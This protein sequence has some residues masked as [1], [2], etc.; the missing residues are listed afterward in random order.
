MLIV[1]VPGGIRSGRSRQLSSNGYELAGAEQ[2]PAAGVPPVAGDG[3]QAGDGPHRHAAA[4]VALQAVVQAD[5][6]RAAEQRREPGVLAGELLDVVDRQP[7]DVRHLRRRVLLQHALAE[8]LRAE[9]VA[10]AG[11]RSSCQ[12]VAEDDVHH[13]QGQRRVGA[14]A[15]RDPPVGLRG[16]RAAVR[17]DG[18]DLRA[19]ACGPGASI[20]QRWMLVTRCS[21]P[22]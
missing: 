2:R 15:D 18:D 14:G 17:V 1:R 4:A 21:S 9:A 16:G 3:R 6:R 22:S 20:A 5:E 11:S 12:P 8:L 13:A 7:G 10:F 19:R